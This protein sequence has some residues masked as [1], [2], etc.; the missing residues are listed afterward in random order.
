MLLI[1][2]DSI[3]MVYV[4]LLKCKS[5]IQ[6]INNVLSFSHWYIKIYMIIYEYMIFKYI[7]Q[8]SPLLYICWN[9]CLPLHGLPICSLS[10]EISTFFRGSYLWKLCTTKVMKRIP[11]I[12]F[13]L[14]A[15]LFYLTNLFYNQFGIAF[16]YY[17]R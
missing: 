12:S 10:F 1:T 6:L 17:V 13:P 15:L 4:S 9:Y 3:L 2:N 14:A 7:L 8:A 5:F 16:E 11:M